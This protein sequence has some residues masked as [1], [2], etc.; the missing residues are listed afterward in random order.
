M[1]T[2]HKY[3][4]AIKAWAEGRSVQFFGA[5]KKWRDYDGLP[6]CVPA[7]NTDGLEW[8]VKPQPEFVRARAYRTRSGD[9]RVAREERWASVERLSIFSCWASE[10]VDIEVTA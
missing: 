7:F 4:D 6:P 3:A 1:S 9:V 10:P 2:P 8:R 5:G